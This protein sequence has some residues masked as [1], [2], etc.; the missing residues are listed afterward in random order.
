MKNLILF[1]CL[2]FFDLSIQA[3]NVKVLKATA[4]YILKDVDSTF[5][6]THGMESKNDFVIDTN[7]NNH[8][9][10][11]L[12]LPLNNGKYAEFGDTL[13]LEMLGNIMLCLYQGE[14]KKN[15]HYMVKIDYYIGNFIYY[16]VDKSSGKVD[17][18][19]K[20]NSNFDE[21]S[22]SPSSMVCTYN[23]VNI[24]KGNAGIMVKNLK[25]NKTIQIT[26]FNNLNRRNYNSQGCYKYRWITDDSLLV[27]KDT[28]YT[29][30]NKWI[31]QNCYLV[32]IKNK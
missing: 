16:L 10:G 13:T 4:D 24:E 30:N 6:A 21:P 7:I 28:Y 25:T 15:G 18:L 23:F 31:N 11:I 8:K 3:Q 2:N 1:F 26:L 9:N 19:N 29:E 5:A 27:Y 32:E 12:K 20:T 22:F 14:N 17:T